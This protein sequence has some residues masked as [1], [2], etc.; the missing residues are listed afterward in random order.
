M[1]RRSAEHVMN[2]MVIAIFERLKNLDDEWQFVD[3][4]TAEEPADPHM[5][6]PKPSPSPTLPNTEENTNT[7][8]SDV[9]KVLESQAKLTESPKTEEPTSTTDETTDSPNTPTVTES[10][11][12]PVVDPNPETESTAGNKKEYHCVCNDKTF[13]YILFTSRR[14]HF[15]KSLWFTSHSRITSSPYLIIKPSR[16]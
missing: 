6:T 2:N 9:T 5:S 7:D 10:V 8:Q 13:I 16:T 11:S 14:T 3:T 15:I 12:A 4:P 1:L